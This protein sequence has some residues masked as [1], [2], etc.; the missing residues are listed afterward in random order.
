MREGDDELDI[1][2]RTLEA[3]KERRLKKKKIGRKRERE[4]ERNQETH[5]KKK[6]INAIKR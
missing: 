5:Q 4:R 1:N 6:N 2:G 3:L